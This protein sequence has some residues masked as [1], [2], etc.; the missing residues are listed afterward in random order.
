MNKR[1]L[2]IILVAAGIIT[3][4][5]VAILVAEGYRFDRRT[6]TLRGTGIISVS[7]IPSGAAIYLD[8]ELTSASN[9]NIND[10]DPKTYVLKVSK[11]GFSSWQKQVT[12]EAGKVTL[13][14]VTLFPIAPDLRPLTFT[15]VVNPQLS[16][17][18]QKIAYAISDPPKA[19]LW[20]L[21]ITNR[22]F[23]FSRDPKQ[24]A[25]DDAS[26]TF[27]T[28]TFSWVP[29]SKTVLVTGTT[30]KTTVSAAKQVAYLLDIDRLND[31]PV[32]ILPTLTQIKAG[33]QTDIDLKSR[34]RLSRLPDSV[35]T[36]AT[37]SAKIKWSPDETKVALPKEGQIQVYDLKKDAWGNI[38]KPKDFIWYP[39][40]DHLVLVDEGSVSIIETDGSNKTT[41]YAGSFEDSLVFP[42]P[43]G[44]KVVILASFNKAAGSNLYSI[45]LR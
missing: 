6:G 21:D 3:V 7:S 5:I 38:G 37:D 8:G 44:S 2:S 40:S 15:G 17:D 9:N 30:T 35:K 20:V 31:S 41:I 23:T 29:D 4:T 13:V 25:K 11:D 1:A 32:D 45:N 33:W 19:G 43:D 36:L 12:V 42:W 14:E 27:S 28:A 22:P 39:D 24:F 16:P 10:L 34:D 18:G 26:F